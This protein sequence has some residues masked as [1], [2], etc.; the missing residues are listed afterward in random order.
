MSAADASAER[1]A[2]FLA[3]T[4]EVGMVIVRKLRSMVEGDDPAQVDRAIMAYPRVARALR[5]TLLMEARFEDDAREAARVD[6]EA[7][8]A[9]AKVVRD[10]RRDRLNARLHKIIRETIELDGEMD[11]HQTD[12]YLACLDHLRESLSD[13]DAD[14]ALFD[15]P[16]EE[17]VTYLRDL[18]GFPEL[19]DEDDDE[20]GGDDDPA[21][22]DPADDDPDDDDPDDDDAGE[23]DQAA[24]GA[25]AAP[26]DPP[27][28]A[29]PDPPQDPPQGPPTDPA[30]LVTW[31]QHPEHPLDCECTAPGCGYPP[32]WTPR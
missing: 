1:R 2:A 18:L 17:A 5:Q 6:A 32:Y 9:E 14:P 21:D 13:E 30:A 27:P 23:D 3:E 24:D 28:E 10:R 26:P 31:R 4:A 12:D 11:E 7:K 20:D 25:E 19:D 16:F 15:L 8:A 29:P 22:D